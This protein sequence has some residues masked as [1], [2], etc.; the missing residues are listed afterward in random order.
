MKANALILAAVLVCAAL[1]ESAT[2][3]EHFFVA[4]LNG[5][6]ESPPNGSPAGATAFVT[7]DLDLVTMRVESSFVG[8][9]GTTTSASVHGVTATAGSGVAGIAT[10]IPGFPPGLTSGSID[11]T[12]DLTT[13]AAYDPAFITASGGTVSDALNALIFGMEDGKTY[14]EIQSTAFPSGEVRGFLTEVVPEPAS[15]A[16]LLT[17]GPLL[18]LRVRRNG[19]RS[20]KMRPR[21]GRSAVGC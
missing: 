17:A 7:L 18:T 16:L 12:I 9:L 1:V 10:P 21:H 4:T 13:G 11:Q 15:L 3:H 20:D 14:L 5:A 2:A 6:S 19:G 8:L